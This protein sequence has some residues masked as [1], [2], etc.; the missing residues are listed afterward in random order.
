M[1]ILLVILLVVVTIGL[2]EI[3]GFPFVGK[4]SEIITSFL[5]IS[6]IAGLITALD[7]SASLG[8]HTRW[9]SIPAGVCMGPW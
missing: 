9:I 7:L 3:L 5:S 8:L 1:V 6:T 4:G 2:V